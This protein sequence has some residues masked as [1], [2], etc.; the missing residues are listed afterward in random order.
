MGIGR[1]V[2]VRVRARVSV[3]DRIRIDKV[4]GL[5]LGMAFMV[6]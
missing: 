1:Y 6:L 2:P 5:G 3:W 4:L